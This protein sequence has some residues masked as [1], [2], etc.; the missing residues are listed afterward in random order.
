MADEPQPA[1]ECGECVVRAAATAAATAAAAAAAEA[2]ERDVAE[3][4][5]MAANRGAGKVAG[6]DWIW[7]CEFLR[8][9]MGDLENLE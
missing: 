4:R 7:M 9:L 6:Y 3:S 8:D 1:G 5:S 2:A